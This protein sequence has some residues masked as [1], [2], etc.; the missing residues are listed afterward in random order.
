MKSS[1][2]G[3]EE[4][5]AHVISENQYL[6][7]ATSAGEA[8]WICALA[9][10]LLAGG[11]FYF[12]SQADS[13]HSQ[14]IARNANVSGVF[15]D[16]RASTE[17]VESFQFCG[18]AE[19]VPHTHESLRDLFAGSIKRYGR[20]HIQDKVTAALKSENTRYF[21]VQVRE[22]YVLD[23]EAWRLSKVDKRER[24]NVAEVFAI[25]A[26]QA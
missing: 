13:L 1:N 23:Q 26:T 8:N 14:N 7:L 15:Y 19:I 17:D 10:S 12:A 21:K 2:G 16:T 11:A 5:A 6:A 20:D 25:V 18:I 22:G 3:A 9:Y 24:V 4:R